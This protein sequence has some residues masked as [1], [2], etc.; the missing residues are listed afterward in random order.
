MGGELPEHQSVYRIMQ[1]LHRM[2]RQHSSRDHELY[3]L[4]QQSQKW[5]PHF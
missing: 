2:K 5:L 3:S 1:I 4:I